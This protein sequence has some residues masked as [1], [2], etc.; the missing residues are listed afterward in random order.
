MN[1][2]IQLPPLT[3]VIEFSEKYYVAHCPELDVTTQGE[4]M[5]EAGRNIQ[6]AVELLLEYSDDIELARRLGRGVSIR[7]LHLA[8]A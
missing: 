6:E 7:P 5:E 2:T 3:A 8:N 1:N 4:T